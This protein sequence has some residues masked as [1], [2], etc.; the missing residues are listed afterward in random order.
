MT[1]LLEQNDL[2]H[3]ELPTS[4]PDATGRSKHKQ[5]AHSAPVTSLIHKL[6]PICWSLFVR[7]ILKDLCCCLKTRNPLESVRIHTRGSGLPIKLIFTC[8]ARQICKY[9]IKCSAHIVLDTLVSATVSHRVEKSLSSR[10]CQSQ[11]DRRSDCITSR[12]MAGLK[13]ASILRGKVGGVKQLLLFVYATQQHMSEWWG[14]S[15]AW[16]ARLPA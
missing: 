16:A 9:P 11:L 13:P 10:C 12:V 14:P 3:A 4:S 5:M 7:F 6:L 15:P 1:F 2:I 8:C